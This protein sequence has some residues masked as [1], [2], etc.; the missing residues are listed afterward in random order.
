MTLKTTLNRVILVLTL[1]ASLVGCHEN[2]NSIDQQL[3]AAATEL[4][5]T[6]PIEIDE[7]TRLDGA[8][9]RKGNIFQYNYTLIN[10]P[11]SEIDSNEFKNHLA[12][13][14]TNFVKTSPDMKPFR[15]NGTTIIYHYRGMNGSYLT[16]IAVTPNQYLD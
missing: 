15:D 14:I 12:P 8:I 1:H 11:A 13:S 2:E 9:A 5:K 3:R 4:N 10:A 7:G 16:Q 6:C